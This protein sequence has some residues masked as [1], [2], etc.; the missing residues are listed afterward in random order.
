MALAKQEDNSM[1]L[2]E[3]EKFQSL[4]QELFQFDCS[5]LD[6]GIYR[7]MNH[8]RQVIERFI[9]EDLPKA[10][11]EE[12]RRGALAEQGQAQQ[13]LAAARQR[14]L[15]ALTGLYPKKWTAY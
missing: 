11:A 3:L 5:D 9:A 7:I 1:S 6:F 10:I 14:V 15:E 13:T 8:K 12:L 2:K 4:L